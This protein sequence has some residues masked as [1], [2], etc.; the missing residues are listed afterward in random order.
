MRLLTKI[1]ILTLALLNTAYLY[2]A[3]TVSSLK[4]LEFITGYLASRG[5]AKIAGAFEA[6]AGQVITCKIKKAASPLIFQA[7]VL[8][9]G[10]AQIRGRFDN[11]NWTSWQTALS[12]QVWSIAH[13][14]NK[15]VTNSCKNYRTCKMGVIAVGYKGLAAQMRLDNGTHTCSSSWKLTANYSTSSLP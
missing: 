4:K 3:E 15:L 1:L 12:T 8:K 5:V 7:R 13:N 14:K 9:N 11:G 6:H 2:S 10:N